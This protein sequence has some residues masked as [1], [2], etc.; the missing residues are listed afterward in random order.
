MYYS[1]WVCD[2][3]HVRLADSY[4]AILS[5]DAITRPTLWLAHSPLASEPPQYGYISTLSTKTDALRR[6]STLSTQTALSE[7]RHLSC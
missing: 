2:Y 7:R 3:P 1:V 4:S 6:K 5:F